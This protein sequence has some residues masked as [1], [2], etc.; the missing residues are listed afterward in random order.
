M[1]KVKSARSFRIATT[2]ALLVAAV[3][4]V[5]VFST[6]NLVRDGLFYRQEIMSKEMLPFWRELAEDE[7]GK[8]TTALIE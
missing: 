7:E 5:Y 2:I 8:N 4:L 6:I 1:L 3:S